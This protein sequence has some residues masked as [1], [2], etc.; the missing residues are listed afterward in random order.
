M[1]NIVVP[2]RDLINE[3]TIRNTSSI[4]LSREIHEGNEP[5]VLSA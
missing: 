4:T 2:V 5:D 1:P 3:W